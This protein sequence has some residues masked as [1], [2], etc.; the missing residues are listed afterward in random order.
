MKLCMF[1]R[2]AVYAMAVFLAAFS[3]SL[4]AKSMENPVFTAFNE[5]L[6]FDQF[7]A[8]AV[9]AAKDQTI[10]DMKSGLKAIYKV[11]G[12]ERTFENTLKAFDNLFDRMNTVWS[13][14]YLMA[15]THP[16]D[17]LRN[18]CNEANIAFEKFANALAM[19]EKLYNAVKAY[20]E[21]EEAKSLTGYQK[22]YLEETLRDFRRNGFGLAK[23][24]RDEL[25]V[26]KD[27]I[28][29]ISNTFQ[30]HIREYEDSLIVGEAEVR[31]L[32]EDYKKARVRE[33]GTY[34][35][36]LS[37]PSYIPFMEY[38]ESD[39]ARKA[40]Y[41][42]FTNRARESNLDVL[43]D[44]FLHRQKMV[45][46]L[47]YNTYAEYGL[48][49]R[50]AKNPKSVWDFEYNLRDQV[51]E[52]A[53]LDYQ[54]LLEAK[55]K[56]LNDPDSDTI[57]SWE[58]SYYNTLLLRTKYDLDPEEVK[59]YLELN[60]VLNGLFM[61]TQ[62]LFDVTYKEV[63]DAPVWH[64]DV[65]MFEVYQDNK[66]IGRFYMDMFPRKNK[67]SHAACFGLVKGRETEQGYQLPSAAMVCNFSKATEDKPSLLT[68]EE[69]TTFFHE[70]GHLLHNILTRSPLSGYAGT[71]VERD[72]VEVPSQILENWAWDYASLEMFAR[73]YQSDEVLPKAL[74]DKM[75]AAK[76]VNS[77]NN[78][79]Q[80][81]YYG[82]LDMTFH[83]KYNPA[84]TIS[85]TQIVED[86]QNEVT[87]FPYVK[88][89]HFHAA[90]GHLTGY[91]AGYY[92]YLWAL[93]Y[94][95]DM[96]SVFEENGILDK[97]TGKELRDKVYAKGGTEDP[98]ILVKDFLGREPNQKAF[99]K[100]LGLK[101]Q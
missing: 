92:G 79:L 63:T 11:P 42:K 62:T 86:L 71:S 82:L 19:D 29:E 74:F 69:T 99:L 75:V 51:K 44:L 100:F 96:F 28:T 66:L 97:E 88:G 61:I 9:T 98:M 5:P 7:T 37:Y 34:K 50:M 76:N 56:H 17:A 57:Y 81:I 67:F 40:L 52:K 101:V 16:D 73:H 20:S 53:K 25:K 87:L 32:P 13:S 59:Q 26:L 10:E 22:K 43:D 72:F 58:K 70:F 77:G 49:T 23:E 41:L 90:F 36:D 46:L 1:N 65:R 2:V 68:H 84:G 48:E 91:A 4:S 12:K 55:R 94:A 80:Q 24:K 33:D 38:S 21:T 31:G 15:Y 83:D 64:E 47:G 8:E 89:S 3:F 54:E 95:Q 45:K 85:T 27:K 30:K 93:V 35:I 14:V 39:S 60:N 78:T 18:A 6:A